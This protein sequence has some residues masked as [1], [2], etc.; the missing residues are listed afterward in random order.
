MQQ[1][2]N[3]IHRYIRAIFSQRVIRQVRKA[4]LSFLS[5]MA[6]TGI[7]RTVRRI[8]KRKI[9]GILVEAGCALGGSA[10]VISKAKTTQRPFY[11]YD[12]FGMIPSPSENDGTDAHDRYEIIASGQAKGIDQNLYYGYE[13]GLLSKVKKNFQDFDISI[14]QENIYFIKGLYQDTFRIRED[15]AFAHIDA[16]WYDSVMVCLKEI[17]P[18][19]VSGAVMII[20]DYYDWEGCKKAVDTYFADKLE[21]FQFVNKSRLHIIRN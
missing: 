17:E 13:Q 16:D 6:L 20:D 21:K 15:V 11:V 3:I 14:N 1:K 10:I 5:P 19:L 8:E 7:Y 2:L 9:K 18:H 4:K 12:T